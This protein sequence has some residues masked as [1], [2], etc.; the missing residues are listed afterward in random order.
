MTALQASTLKDG[1]PFRSTTY[2]RVARQW[3]KIVKAAGIRHC[4]FHDMRRTFCTDLARLGVN[5]RVVQQ[6]AGHASAMTTARYY[7]HVDDGMKRD[8]ITRLGKG[9]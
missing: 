9:A 2:D 5:Q 3:R 6:L 7:Q 8:A 4:T 1:G